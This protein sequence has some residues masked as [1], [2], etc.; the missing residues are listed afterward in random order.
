MS[1]SSNAEYIP[2]K[3]CGNLI[4]ADL[5]RKFPGVPFSVRMSRGTGYGTFYI[6]WTDGPTDAQVRAVIGRYEGQGFD[7]MTDCAYPHDPELQATPDGLRVV[8]YGTKY[9][10][11]TRSHSAEFD[12]HILA[13]HGPTYWADWESMSEYDRQ[14]RLWQAAERTERTAQGFRTVEEA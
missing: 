5:R 8:R 9:L 7:G 12:A 4:R 11:T 1:N 14:R 6:T 2:A 3:E 13:H 10:L